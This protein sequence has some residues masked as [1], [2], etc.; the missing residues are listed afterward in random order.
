MRLNLNTPLY[1]FPLGLLGFI[2]VTYV[3]ATLQLSFFHPGGVKHASQVS[4]KES[5]LKEEK[6]E[7][8]KEE[9]LAN[10]KA[11][12]LDSR[13]ES[14]DVIVDDLQLV[15]SKR[16]LR[17]GKTEKVILEKVNA[18][19]PAGQVSVIMG[20]SGVSENFVKALASQFSAYVVVERF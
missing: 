4:S 13:K 19:F 5:K 11:A 1:V 20:P 3:W 15:V 17:G 2:I 18:R 10:D 16:N 6:D 7:K 14:V 12:Q 8:E 9:K